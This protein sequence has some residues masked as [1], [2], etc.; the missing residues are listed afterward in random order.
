MY[1]LA[2]AR[3]VQVLTHLRVHQLVRNVPLE[4]LARRPALV[5]QLAAALCLAQS[6]LTLYLER[7]QMIPRP[8]LSALYVQQ[9]AL[10]PQPDSL[11]QRAQGNARLV[12]IHQKV[13]QVA[14]PVQAVHLVHQ[15]V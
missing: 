11:R 12:R 3:V 10:E 1:L 14:L 15:S 13:R 8:L 6:D 9:V 5:Q 4:R 2:L 7:L